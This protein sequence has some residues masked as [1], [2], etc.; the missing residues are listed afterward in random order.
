MLRSYHIL[1]YGG[2]MK[3]YK[4]KVCVYAICKNEEKFVDRWYES[5]KEADEIYV[6]DTGSGDG[7]VDKLKSHG[8][9]VKVMEIKPW[10]FDRARNMSLEMVPEDTDI[11]V[12]TD[13]D[14]VFLPGW[15]SMLE[16]SWQDDTKRLR[17]TYNWKLEKDTPVVSFFYE[18]IH[19]RKGYKWIY[20]VHEILKYE[21]EDEKIVYNEGIVLNHYPDSSKSRG[22]YLGLLELSVKENPDDDRNRH[23]LGREY[24]YH[25]RWNDAIGN[26][27]IHL[28]LKKA[29]WR[30]ERAASM[31]YIGR[32]YKNM[33]RIDEARLWYLKAIDEASHL[34]DGLVEMGMLEYTE[35]NY[36]E[37]IKYLTKA[38]T[39]K[40][41]QKT[42][43]NEIFSWD[44]TI[45]NLLSVS[46]YYL[47][48]YDIS[49]FYIE[50]A[51]KIDPD[52]KMLIDNE[53]LIRDK[54][55]DQS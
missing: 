21:G 53:K 23:Y 4:Y 10:R 17:Y 47:G 44:Y 26:L 33:G 1:L 6:L 43:I 55:K 14:E 12:C 19:A 35:G 7:T 15:R 41:H 5:M 28:G 22:S 36:L 2:V 50:R 20:P 11:C 16:D 38:L 45:D 34:R 13:L 40:K 9:E 18:K 37:A 51:R 48:L 3:K 39:I 8:V 27:I 24:M 25:G 31:R 54:I 52:N 46:Y 49:L 32:C 29:T 42:Y 30:D